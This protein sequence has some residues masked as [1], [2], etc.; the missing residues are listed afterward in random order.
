METVI[1]KLAASVWKLS[2]HLLVLCSCCAVT[3]SQTYQLKTTKIILQFCK[4]ETDMSP[5]GLKSGCL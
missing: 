3:L 2:T 5:M 1:D 4:S